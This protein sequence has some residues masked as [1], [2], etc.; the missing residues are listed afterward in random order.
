M[1]KK[2]IFFV[3]MIISINCVIVYGQPGGGGGGG[4]N[5]NDP[6]DPGNGGSPSGWVPIDGGLA[7]L[8]AAGVGY[9]AKKAYDYRSKRQ[10]KSTNTLD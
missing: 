2:S 8:L 1:L 10:K 9:G 6:I 3:L 5:P 7:A 4:G